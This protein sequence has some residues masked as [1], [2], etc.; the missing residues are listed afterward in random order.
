MVEIVAAP[1]VVVTVAEEV[2]AVTVVAMAKGLAVP[3]GLDGSG[4]LSAPHGEGRH[5]E[6]SRGTDGRAVR[7]PSGLGWEPVPCGEES[8]LGTKSGQ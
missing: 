7:H 4:L 2:A 1:V 5:L 3:G 6:V 8:N